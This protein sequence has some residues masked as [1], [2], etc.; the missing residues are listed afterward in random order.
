MWEP[1]GTAAW[2]PWDMDAQV[3]KDADAREPRDTDALE[4]R[5]TDARELQDTDAREPWDKDMGELWDADTQEPQD[6]WTVGRG[7]SVP[8]QQ[9]AHQ[10]VEGVRQLL[11]H[12]Q[13]PACCHLA[14]ALVLLQVEV[15]G[16]VPDVL[17][18]HDTCGGDGAGRSG[19]RP[20]S[21]VAVASRCLARGT[22]T[23]C[24]SQG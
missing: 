20:P 23:H 5:D 11:G 13:L 10:V 19:V 14:L 22:G 24:P 15:Q 8:C 9:P 6:T 2:G 17:L 1:W 16:P 4:L 3:L 7:C 12:L 21:I 18:H